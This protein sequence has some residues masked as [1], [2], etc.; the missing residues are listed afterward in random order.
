L[1]N[2]LTLT[3]G[4][5]TYPKTIT[6][7]SLSDYNEI[8]ILFTTSE[9]SSTEGIHFSQMMISYKNLANYFEGFLNNWFNYSD[10][11]EP[12]YELF[13]GTYYN[14]HLYPSFYFLSIIQAIEA[15]HRRIYR[16]RGNY[17]SDIEYEPLRNDLT[18]A[19]ITRLSDGNAYPTGFRDALKSRIKYGNEISLRTRLKQLSNDI[20]GSFDAK[21]YVNRDR[22]INDIVCTR[23]Y[24]THYEKDPGMICRVFEGTD[25]NYVN[26]IL[27]SLFIIVL[28]THMG[29]P[30]QDAF[31]IVRKQS[32]TN[33]INEIFKD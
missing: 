14:T 5:P 33:A 29:I 31:R 15:F 21:I 22:F 28:L 4:K 27:K 16:D 25:L 23:N 2:F 32:L 30:K 7:Y 17:L 20:W 8:E 24:L 11:L 18:N 12:V 10:A 3:I 19:I 9:I 26:I 6:A 13:F 1:G